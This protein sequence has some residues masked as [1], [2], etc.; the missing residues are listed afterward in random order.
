VKLN[1]QIETVASSISSAALIRLTLR[2]YRAAFGP[3]N[4]LLRGSRLSLQSGD[5]LR[6]RFK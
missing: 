2:P 3:S 6:A 5:F 1:A 4:K